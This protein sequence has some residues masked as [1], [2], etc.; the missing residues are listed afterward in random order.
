MAVGVAEEETVSEKLA[1]AAALEVPLAG[2]LE[3]LTVAEVQE[4]GEGL[5]LAALA[6]AVARALALPPPPARVPEGVVL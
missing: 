3:W 6:V 4:E 2:V 5:P 1:L